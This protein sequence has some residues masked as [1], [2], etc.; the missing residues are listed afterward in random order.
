MP[1]KIAGEWLHACSGCEMA[2]LNTGPFLLDLFSQTRFVHFPFLMDQ[3]PEQNLLK[4]GTPDIP[5]ADIGLVSG[6]IRTRAHL[7]TAVKM[8][9]Q[10]DLIVAFGTCA[11][12]GGIPAMIN[13]HPNTELLQ[14]CY[15]VDDPALFESCGLPGLL[16]RCYALDEKIKVDIMLPGCPPHAA[17]IKRLMTHLISREPF[18]PPQKSVCDTCPLVRKG[19]GGIGRL[20]RCL[21][22]MPFKPDADIN[23]VDCFLEQGYLCMG[24]VTR[25]GCADKGEP[26]CITARVP[27]RGCY[28]PVLPEGNPLLDM[29]TALA[30][31]KVDTD[32][33]ADPENLLRFTGAH[34]RLTSK[35]K[36]GS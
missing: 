33:L 8:R 34:N 23:T 3:P 22:P 13:S 1:L 26:R 32:A 18:E 11:T 19:K 14:N 9:Q 30:S 21:E 16:D 31:N 25:A 7:D 10:C 20:S 4:N 29:L 36:Q 12:H 15:G 2:I 6:S 28:G 5:K 35:L 17:E 24:P 27:C